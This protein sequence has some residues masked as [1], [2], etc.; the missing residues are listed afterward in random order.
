MYYYLFIS[1]IAFESLI[2]KCKWGAAAE[3]L[4]SP[5]ILEHEKRQEFKSVSFLK[6]DPIAEE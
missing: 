3:D 5:V 4:S 2:Y 1:G 6:R